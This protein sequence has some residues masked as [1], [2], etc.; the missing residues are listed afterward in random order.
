MA[1]SPDGNLFIAPLDKLAS[2]PDVRCVR[3]GIT[4]EHLRQRATALTDMQA[5]ENPDEARAALF[6]RIPA[7][8][9]R[10]TAG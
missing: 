8:T 4:L 6:K 7:A 5:A 2:L 1:L 9:R 10:S 3:E